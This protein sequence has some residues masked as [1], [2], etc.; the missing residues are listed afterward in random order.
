MLSDKPLST[1]LEQFFTDLSQYAGQFFLQGENGDIRHWADCRCPLVYIYNQ[2]INFVPMFLLYAEER[3]VKGLGNADFNT[4]GAF[5]ELTREETFIL[6]HASDNQAQNYA[7]ILSVSEE[8][9]TDIV[10]FRT[11]LL[12]TLQLKEMTDG[13]TEKGSGPTHIT[14]DP[15]LFGTNKNILK[16]E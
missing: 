1:A 14:I 16:P 13:E 7:K 15:G 9:I 5:L 11:K 4:A 8:I 10:F 6:A 2:K 12:E 3:G